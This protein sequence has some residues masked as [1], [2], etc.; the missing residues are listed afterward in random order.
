MTASFSTVR[1]LLVSTIV[2]V[3]AATLSGCGRKAEPEMPRATGPIEARPVGIPIG[4]T[5]PA[6][7]AAKPQKKSFLL[8]PLL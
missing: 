6:P 5:T 4:P 1:F 7:E 3:G 8:D 2:V